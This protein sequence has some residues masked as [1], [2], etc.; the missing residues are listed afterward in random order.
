MV[1]D[2]EAR[3]DNQTAPQGRPVLL[4]VAVAVDLARMYLRMKLL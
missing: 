3:P 4:V 2:R 1:L